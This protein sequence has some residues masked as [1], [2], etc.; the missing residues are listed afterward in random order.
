M[1]IS[2]YNNDDNKLGFYFKC[3]H[4]LFADFK[5]NFVDFQNFQKFNENRILF[6][7]NF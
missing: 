6:E 1:Y 2:F 3:K 5:K 4:V 7:T